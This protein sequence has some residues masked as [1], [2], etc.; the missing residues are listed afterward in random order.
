MFDRLRNLFRKSTARTVK[1]PGIMVRTYLPAYQQNEANFDF[2]TNGQGEDANLYT[3]LPVL[4][5][6]SRALYHTNS[7]LTKFDQT[8]R[9]NVVGS[10]GYMFQSRVWDREPKVGTGGKL[11]PGLPDIGANMK[12]EEAFTEWQQAEFCTVTGKMPWQQVRE[13][14]ISMTARDG[15]CM[16]RLFR[17]RNV[18]KF[19]F[20]TQL[21]NIDCLAHEKNEQLR[22]GVEIRMGIERNQWGKTLAYHLHKRGEAD[23]RSTSNDYGRSGTFRVPADE[24]ILSCKLTDADATLAAPW[25]TPVM[26]LAYQ[27]DALIEAEVVACR[28]AACKGG[29]FKNTMSADDGAGLADSR[30]WQGDKIQ[31]VG[32]NEMRELPYGWEFVQYDPKHPTAHFAEARKALTQAA[33]VGLRVPYYTLSADLAD[34]NY[35]SMRVGEIDVRENWKLIQ[36]W[37]IQ[38]NEIPVFT[39]FLEQSLLM[40]AIDLPE[41]K[42]EK[43]N[44]PTFRGKRW[45]WI[46]PVKEVQAHIE[47]LKHGF[48]T[49]ARIVADMTQADWEDIIQERATENA[50]L[51]ALGLDH[52]T[53]EGINNA[54]IPPPPEPAEDDDEEKPKPKKKPAAKSRFLTNGTH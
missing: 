3:A 38:C 42:F 15:A 20:S 53:D 46:D 18:N 23:F 24:I 11:I 34:A 28:A 26:Q 50:V 43:Y 41:E 44:R 25:C 27:I 52:L 14:R 35:S 12:I 17:G 36:T 30:T 49:R 47:A 2:F 31:N 39:P 29:F 33:A 32:P 21:L 13:E 19:G 7:I 1:G 9:V 6:Q 4:R 48:T 5:R 51:E 10:E 45:S 16:L 54:G 22:N 40:R 8:L 37:D